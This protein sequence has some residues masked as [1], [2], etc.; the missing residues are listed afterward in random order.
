[1][2]DLNRYRDIIDL[3]DKEMI[4]LFEQRMNIAHKIGNYKKDKGIEVKNQDREND[5][6]KRCISSLSDDTY[7]YEISEFMKNMMIAMLFTG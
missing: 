7:S 1:M 2:D 6:I 5:I 3:I 4:R